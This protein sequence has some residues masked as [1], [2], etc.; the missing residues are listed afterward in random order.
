MGNYCLAHRASEWEADNDELD[1]LMK[2]IAEEIADMDARANLIKT[3][4]EIADIDAQLDAS[5]VEDHPVR[6]VV[7][8]TCNELLLRGERIPLLY[9][10][11][12]L[13]W[14]ANTESSYKL[15]QK[16]LRDAQVLM[17]YVY[18]LISS[19]NAC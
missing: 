14:L 1:M 3:A 18:R 8:S 12:L 19:V 13:V 16:R 2:D 17:W 10:A 7:R 4:E 6:S 5:E 15:I 9:R 11:Q